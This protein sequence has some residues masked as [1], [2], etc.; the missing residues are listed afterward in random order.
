MYFL[1]CLNRLALAL[2]RSPAEELP[3]IL[4]GSL[5]QLL[6]PTCHPKVLGIRL[7]RKVRAATIYLIVRVV[8]AHEAA[9]MLR[10]SASVPSGVLAVR[11]TGPAR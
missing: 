2:Q 1:R 9:G 4:G 8:V 10:G 11:D 5:L 3:C 7:A 6:V